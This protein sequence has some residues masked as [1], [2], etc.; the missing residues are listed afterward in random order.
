MGNLANLLASVAVGDGQGLAVDLDDICITGL[1]DGLAV[2][3]EL[4]VGAAL[5]G[6]RKGH[7]GVQVVVAR[8]G[9]QAIGA[10]PLRPRYAPVV[11]RVFA[12]GVPADAMLMRE[13]GQ[14]QAAVVTVLRKRIRLVVAEEDLGIRRPV[15]DRGVPGV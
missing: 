10:G 9:G 4:D 12:I 3:T 14:L 5:P 7:V 6:G 1:G 13:G 8:I 11:F 2:E 15:H